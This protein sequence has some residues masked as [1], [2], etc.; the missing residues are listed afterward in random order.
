[1]AGT[2]IA[3]LA[4]G[5]AYGMLF[6][7]ILNIFFV[8]H[9]NARPTISCE[10]FDVDKEKV[11]VLSPYQ[12]LYF[13]ASDA[14][15][16]K[17]TKCSSTHAHDATIV[18]INGHLVNRIDASVAEGFA[19]FYRFIKKSD[20]KFVFWNWETHPKEILIRTEPRFELLFRDSENLETLLQQMDIVVPIDLTARPFYYR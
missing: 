9:R 17:I 3:S 18:V 13:P 11:L 8:L 14:T 19:H 7:I 12:S 6:G 10:L 20:K 15:L 1:M 4:L 5:L 2:F 16:R